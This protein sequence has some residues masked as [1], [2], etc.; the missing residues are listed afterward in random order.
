[1]LH[2][3]NFQVGYNDTLKVWLSP[4]F[5]QQQLDSA[6]AWL[7]EFSQFT[8]IPI[9]YSSQ[10]FSY[11]VSDIYT[12]N[13]GVNISP[14]TSNCNQITHTLPTGENINAAANITNNNGNKE[15]FDKELHR[16][17]GMS[18]IA[19]RLGV[20]NANPNQVNDKDGATDRV[21]VYMSKKH[22]R[23]GKHDIHTQPMTHLTETPTYATQTKIGH[24]RF[25]GTTR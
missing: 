18:E 14:G 2:R 6:Y 16:A 12:G 7:A 10:Q 5:S 25:I 15:E 3:Y 17:L 9:Q 4:A 13:L 22:F 21:S 23:E 24:D 8:E 19:Y 1:M 11:P 20:M